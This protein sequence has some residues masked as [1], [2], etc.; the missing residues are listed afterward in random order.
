MR[1]FVYCFVFFLDFD[2]VKSGMTSILFKNLH[3][4]TDESKYEIHQIYDEITEHIFSQLLVDLS[5]KVIVLHFDSVTSDYMNYAIL[6]NNREIIQLSTKRSSKSI[7]L[8][9]TLMLNYDTMKTAQLH[10]GYIMSHSTVHIV[11]LMDVSRF[12]TIC[13]SHLKPSDTI[14]FICHREH[15]SCKDAFIDGELNSSFLTG[16]DFYKAVFNPFIVAFTENRLS[17]YESCFFCGNKAKTISLVYEVQINAE[18]NLESIKLN[19]EINQILKKKHVD[20][21][22]HTFYIAFNL[23]SINFICEK[24][25]NI[26]MHNEAII[27]SCGNSVS[28]EGNMIEEIS[29]RLNF[30]YKLLNFEHTYGKARETLVSLVNESK[31]DFAIGSISITVSRWQKADF[32]YPV[33]QD[34]CKVLYNVQNSIFKEG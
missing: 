1:T 23:G 22:S 19:S 34:P 31:A 24:P 2:G 13:K 16:S 5:A 8:L 9:V 4:N 18:T 28:L 20:F 29:K 3:D 26:S 33:I 32:T 27:I 10:D 17:L 7:N 14:I 6:T 25:T 11:G 30:K 21:N 15:G 12:D